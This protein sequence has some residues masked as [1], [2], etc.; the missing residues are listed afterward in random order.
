MTRSP[1]LLLLAATL[2]GAACGD[3]SDR[4]R[5]DGAAPVE[6]VLAAYTT[7]REAYREI[8][9]AF[10]RM[11]KDS[12]GQDVV[13]RESYQGSG[14]QSRAIVGGFEAHVA[15]LSL[16]ADVDRIAEAGLIT[17]DWRSKPDGGMVSTS[18]VVLAVREGN[19]LGIR[20]WADLARPGLEILT[21]DPQTSG[22]AKWNINAMYGAALRGRAGVPAGDPAAAEAFLASVFR[23]VT[24]MDKGARESITNYEKGIGD[25]AITYENEI[26]VGRAAGQTYEAVIPGSTILIEN[27]VALIDAHVDAD[28]VRA[29]AEAFV[30]FLWS[31]EA[32]RAYAANGLR[33]LDPAV[34]AEFAARYPAVADLWTMEFLGGWTAVDDSLYGAEGRFTR[35]FAT[36]TADR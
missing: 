26:E 33:S 14:A 31:A 28:G 5:S 8:L 29:V 23:N 6:L 7:P 22:G 30:D 2:A 36:A 15:A 21:P 11:W 17:H 13:F 32:Q 3:R 27:P 19:P 34:A 24:I 4:A 10:Q 12:T 25:V 16:E 1:L 35:A 20:D 18:I 9:P